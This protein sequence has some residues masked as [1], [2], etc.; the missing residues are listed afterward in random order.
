MEKPGLYQTVNRHHPDYIAALEKLGITLKEM[1][2]LGEKEAH[3][4]QLA[5]SVACGSEGAAHS[6]T[7]RA[8][9]AGATPAEIRHCV[10]LLTST[11]GF[12]KTMAGMSWVNDILG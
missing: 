3:L 5:A 8:L 6:H 12:P 11:I 1:G 9:E 7:R 4:I 10:F 2:P